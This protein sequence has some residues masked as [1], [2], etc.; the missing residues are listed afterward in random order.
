MRVLVWQWGRR[1]AGPRIA[2]E[3]ALALRRL[4]GATGLLSLSERAE[5]LAGPDAPFCDL[6]VATYGGAAGLLR[7]W[8]LAP[9]GIAALIRQLRRLRPDA[10]ICAMP[11]PLDLLMAAAL[12][13]LGIPFLVVIH[14]AD[15][16][17]G[18]RAPLLMWLQRR[19]ARRADGLVALSTH[20]AERVREQGLA[21][22]GR[23]VLVLRHPPFA[24][25]A[26]PPPPFRHSGPPRLLFF[27]RLLAYK[28][29]DLL[30]EALAL[31]GDAGLEVRVVGS[32]PEGP[33]LDA[34][35]AQKSVTVENRWVAD[36]EIGGVIA[37][38]DMLV[39]P[40]RE[41]SQSGAAAV[42][43]AA[44][45]WV[46]ATNVGGLR[47]QLAEEPLAVLCDPDA[48]SLAKALRDFCNARPAPPEADATRDTGADAAWCDFAGALIG[49]IGR[50]PRRL[51]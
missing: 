17:P 40:Y 38:A 44:G 42:A 33:A 39:L 2:M 36:N 6:P 21:K 31:L 25:G 24:F 7:R 16:H 20:V 49:H 34:L 8:L 46:I 11:G 32:G 43:I 18:E 22:A 10:A 30:A 35:R 47:E 19:L 15:S 14:D 13:W 28:G 41:A 4:P 29:L 27:G 5:I 26:K 23:P 51:R 1:G 37:W 48:A 50:D 45:R 3:L 12:G 9:F